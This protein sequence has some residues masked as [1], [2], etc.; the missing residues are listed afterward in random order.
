MTD[1]RLSPHFGF[2]ELTA[3][4]RAEFALENRKQGLYFTAPLAL[5][6]REVLEPARAALG[7]PLAVHSG[8]RCAG[9]N[10]AVGGAPNSAHLKGL[11][12]DFHA[13]GM[14]VEAAFAV[15]A[16]SAVPFDALILETAVR[17]AAVVRWLH[18]ACAPENP[19]RLTLRKT[20]A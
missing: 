17:G 15:L 5:L 14:S 20:A 7:A 3:T 1:F 16:K 9:L 13:C 18:I 4:T 6:C 19:R 2:Y 11:A 10:C 8:F 12:A